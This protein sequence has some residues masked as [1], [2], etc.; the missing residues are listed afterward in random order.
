[1]NEKKLCALTDEDVSALKDALHG[2]LIGMTFTGGPQVSR[3]AH[4]A[5]ALNPMDQDAAVERMARAI[6]QKAY[7][8]NVDLLGCDV[9]VVARGDAR[10]ALAALL[11]GGQE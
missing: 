7:G 9:W 11:G 8:G 6:L 10:A 1:M 3:I 4:A 2:P 5:N